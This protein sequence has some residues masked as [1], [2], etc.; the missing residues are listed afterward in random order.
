MTPIEASRIITEEMGECYH[1]WKTH[2]NEDCSAEWCVKC[3][4]AKMYIG[5]NPNYT[6]PD[7]FFRA[8]RWVQSKEWWD[9]FLLTLHRN[10]SNWCV[11]NKHI[12]TNC[13]NHETFA[14]TLA[15]WL[16]KRGEK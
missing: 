8:W 9:E 14:I 6:T 1:E 15:E 3:N 10:V 4:K 2:I 13:V 5:D 7:G 16:Q 11:E 12:P